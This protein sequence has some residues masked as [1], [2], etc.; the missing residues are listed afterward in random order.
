MPESEHIAHHV[1]RWGDLPLFAHE[2][3]RAR[4]P[5]PQLVF[6][7]YVDQGPPAL[8]DNDADQPPA[9]DE[10]GRRVVRGIERRQGIAGDVAERSP[11][12][13][14]ARQRRACAIRRS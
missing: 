11:V 10:H 1:L 2:V 7:E 6:A 3:G 13:L 9:A 4:E 14:D 8:V 12:D 5:P